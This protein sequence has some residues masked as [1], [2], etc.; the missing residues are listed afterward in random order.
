MS[1][2]INLLAVLWSYGQVVEVLLFIV[3]VYWCS[4][5]LGP[6]FNPHLL[7]FFVAFLIWFAYVTD[8]SR[9]SMQISSGLGRVNPLRL[10]GFTWYNLC[11]D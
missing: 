3:N 2:I 1:Y 7:R 11:S 5:G 9:I 6:W 10:T 4:S 8:F